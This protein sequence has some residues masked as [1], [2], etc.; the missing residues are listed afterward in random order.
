MY[1]C[2]CTSL[3][4]TPYKQQHKTKKKCVY[5]YHVH[6]YTNNSTNPAKCTLSNEYKRLFVCT[7]K[8]PSKKSQIITP[9]TKKYDSV[10][11][12]SIYPINSQTHTHYNKYKCLYNVYQVTIT[13]TT[14]LNTNEHTLVRNTCNS[15][16]FSTQE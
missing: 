9:N 4:V 10:C 6:H 5:V 13:N 11:T 3:Y 12:H 7:N 14:T 2:A 1:A 15:T 16:Y 8:R